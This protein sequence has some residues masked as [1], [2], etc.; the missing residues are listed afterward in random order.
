MMDSIRRQQIAEVL[1]YDRNVNLQVVN[2]EKKGVE[3]M[4]ETGALSSLQTQHVLDD[5]TELINSLM[6]IL[7]KK[8]ASVLSLPH[9]TAAHARQHTEAVDDLTNIHEVVDAY[10]VIV[11]SYLG[12]NTVQTKQM[13]HS[14]IR[15]LLS[16]V[17]PITRGLSSMLQ[18]YVVN[19]R[20]ERVNIRRYFAK[21]LVALSAYSL[22]E[23]QLRSGSLYN[24]STSCVART[25]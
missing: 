6:V 8:K 12:N 9:Y 23:D 1:N 3:K 4:G 19:R 18:T 2:L 22:I 13:L 17:A 24:V 16:D 5:T 15:R 10:N 11:A 7:D 21:L 25:T 20:T 14:S